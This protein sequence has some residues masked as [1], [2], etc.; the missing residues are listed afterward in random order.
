MNDSPQ[1][2]DAAGPLDRTL[3]TLLRRPPITC[4]QDCTLEQALTRM[5]ELAI[6]SIIVVDGEQRP[7]GVFT[8]PDLLR[9]VALP[10]R[11][12]S[13]KITEVMSTD[14]VTLPPH[15]TAHEAA[16]SMLRRGIRHVL[17]VHDGRLAGVVSERDLFSLQRVSVRQLTQDIQYA[18][19]VEDLKP[20]AGEIR[21]L[22]R[23]LLNQG[24]GAAQV[25]PLIASLNDQ[26][27]HRLVELLL[28][29]QAPAGTRWCWLALGSEGRFEQ[30]LA[31]DQ[32]NGLAFVAPEG[33]S[34]DHVRAQFLPLARS[35][36][37]ALDALGF[38]LCKGNVMA[39][40]PKWCLSEQEWREMFTGWI[41]RGDPHALL[42]ST[43]FFDFRGLCGEVAL[44]ES[45]R[46]WLLAHARTN[47]RFLHQMAANALQNHPPFGLI[48]EFAVARSGEHKGTIDI[49][50]NGVM[51]FTDAARIFSL[52]AGV[53]SCQTAER[54]RESTSALK[55]PESEA[56]G[57]IEAFH[58]LQTLRLRHQMRRYEAGATP[59][60]HVDPDT[61]PPLDRHV[62]REA[63][64]Q[65]KNMQNRLAL[66][67]RL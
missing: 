19:G 5:S 35:V 13:T 16:L 65:A 66:D 62:L 27:T 25:T 24:A 63:L 15:A 51:L 53:A 32:D 4:M 2:N 20:L 47:P 42:N 37:E 48:R 1:T 12:L 50:L 10:R 31:T 57:W 64:R 56:A 49:K 28:A 59:D 7:L 41:D 44:A 45:L 22:A 29:P 55:V 54:L 33:V 30:T 36:N 21:A 9:R 38:P 14:L 11:D 3:G 67:Y 26:L 58:F 6:G 17:V 52:A 8:L 40:N 60:N 39:S 43:I 23:H 46:A 61:L 18:G 34:T